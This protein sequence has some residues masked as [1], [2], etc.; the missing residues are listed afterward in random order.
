MVK[1]CRDY[2]LGNTELSCSTPE[3]SPHNICYSPG[4]F[5]QFR[6]EVNNSL[7]QEWKL[8]NVEIFRLGPNSPA[9]SAVKMGSHYIFTQEVIDNSGTRA[10]YLSYLWLNTSTYEGRIEVT[11]ESGE[12]KSITINMIP[13]GT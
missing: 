4:T 9:P 5:Y 2:Y 13:N 3:G 10:N 6:C 11:C 8:S 12:E 7:R 1:L